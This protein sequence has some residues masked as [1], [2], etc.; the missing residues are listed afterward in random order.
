M[1]SVLLS[2]M[3]GFWLPLYYI[4]AIILSVLLSSGL[5]ILKFGYSEQNIMFLVILKFDYSE[6]N[7]MSLVILKFGYSEQNIMSQLYFVIR[8]LHCA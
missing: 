3:Y 5:V 1:L 2:L 8:G 6:Q 7:I 4:V